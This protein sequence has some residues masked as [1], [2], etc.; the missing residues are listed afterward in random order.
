[1]V[2]PRIILS[3]GIP[4]FRPV[5]GGAIPRFATRASRAGKP[6]TFTT[7]TTTDSDSKPRSQDL[8]EKYSAGELISPRQHIGED[9][10]IVMPS[11]TDIHL[12]MAPGE[13]RVSLLWLRDVCPCPKCV[14]P[15][16][17]QKNFS[18]VDLPDYP[19]LRSAEKLEDGSLKV[20][21]QKD[22]A[23]G[24]GLHESIYPRNVLEEW[25]RDFGIRAT[26]QL[27][28]P[29][30]PWNKSSY[31]TLLESGTTRISYKDWTTDDRVFAEAFAALSRT[32]L[33][34]LTDVPS[35]EQEVERIGN[36]IGM[37]QHTFYG[38]TWDVKSK[39]NAENVAYTSQYLGLH[40]D[41]LYH[42]PIPR[43][44]LLHC[45][46]NSC[47]GGESLFS[48][49]LHA[50]LQIKTS[51]P[52]SFEALTRRCWHFRYD[53]DPH[54]YE[55]VHAVIRVDP[56]TGYI[57]QLSWAPPFQA[58][59]S[60]GYYLGPHGGGNTLVHLK[61]AAARFE[62]EISSPENVLEVKLNPGE[63]VVFDN[64]RV[65]HGR[66]E[67][68]AEGGGSRWLK[69]AYISQQV[70]NAAQERQGKRAGDI[71]VFPLP[72]VAP[73]REELVKRE[74]ANFAE[75]RNRSPR[76]TIIRKVPVDQ[77]TAASAESQA[78]DEL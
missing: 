60:R 26:R 4:S 50:A 19:K 33:I 66:R 55:R 77:K 24:E 54:T 25:A 3:T 5:R 56:Q 16:S 64:T 17:G 37:L 68:A 12:D 22:G 10:K 65:L 53:K 75:L 61:R 29:R 1:M 78:N 15:H 13:V 36:R 57:N 34:F 58:P 39:P 41:L 21:W 73:F 7:K 38:T 42:S 20:V 8:I 62:R 27:P 63:A 40:Q 28:T 48:D 59:F 52:A 35:G 44:Q 76:G 71:G 30:T 23:F 49:G 51:S 45:L 46:E 72:D 67:F 14:D 43:L 9:L 32:G 31:L 47:E 6:A 18:T 70:F 74:M 2:R 11:A 69:G